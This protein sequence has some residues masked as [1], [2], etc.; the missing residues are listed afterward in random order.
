MEFLYIIKPHKENFAETMT[1]EEARV[2][3]IHF[4]YLQQKLKEGKLIMAGPVL[5]GEFGVTVIE[6]ESED[7]ARE[8]MNN[9]PAVVNGVVTPTLYP[10]R[11]S[12]L[13]GR[14]D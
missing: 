10:Y 7:E 6:T 9:D 11:V 5:T 3:G 13:R 12:L 14:N 2:M 4:A 8:F 1:D